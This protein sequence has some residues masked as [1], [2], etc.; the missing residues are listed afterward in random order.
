MYIP[1]FMKTS[2]GVKAILEFCLRNLISC[3]VGIIDGRY[4]R[5]RP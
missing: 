4:L 1:S 2:T 5:I 3:N